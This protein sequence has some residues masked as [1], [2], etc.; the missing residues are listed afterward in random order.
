VSGIIDHPRI[1]RR[2][3]RWLVLLLVATIVAWLLGGLVGDGPTLRGLTGLLGVA[4]L[5]ALFVEV[6]VVGGAAVAGALRAGER[7]DRLA[8]PDVT[9]LPPQLEARLRRR[10]APGA[11]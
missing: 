6:V 8:A 4:V 7:G 2:L 3:R 9:L 1:A 10:R 11:R 5:L